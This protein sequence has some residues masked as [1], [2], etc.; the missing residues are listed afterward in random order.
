MHWNLCRMYGL[1]RVRRSHDSGWPDCSCVTFEIRRGTSSTRAEERVQNRLLDWVTI[2]SAATA[3]LAE[4][5][6]CV[7]GTRCG[8]RFPHLQQQR[9]TSELLPLGDEGPHQF[10]ADAVAAKLFRDD[11][12]FDLPFARSYVGTE[13]TTDVALGFGYQSAC[14]LYR[15][16]DA[17]LVLFRGPMRG[18]WCGLLQGENCWY[19]VQY[20]S[21]NFHGCGRY[22]YWHMSVIPDTGVAQ[23]FQRRS[24]G[25][26]WLRVRRDERF[27][28]ARCAASP[29]GR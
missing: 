21:A 2:V 24:G 3:D 10:C 16:L 1:G 25:C 13:E 8:I 26:S 11:N 20:G 6:I 28:R 7:E 15:A 19:I 29:V 14:C 4:T 23:I 5:V 27:G 17:D 12:I 9:R 22:A 18:D